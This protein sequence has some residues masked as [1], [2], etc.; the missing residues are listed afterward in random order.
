MI[1]FIKTDNPGLGEIDIAKELSNLLS[2]NKKVLWIFSG[3]SN[4]AIENTILRQLDDNKTNNLRILL[5]DERY[6]QKGHKDSNETQLLAAGFN[7]MKADFVPILNEKSL[8]ETT[9]DF[10][11]NLE[12]SL[13]WADISIG[14]FGIGEDGHTSGILPGSNAINS[15]DVAISYR[16]EEFTRITP[17]IKTL[18][19]INIAYVF[20]F[21]KRKII[22]LNNLKDKKGVIENNP[23][24]VFYQISSVYVYND[25]IGEKI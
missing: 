7:P 5:G 16:T 22:A 4:I 24:L 6:G 1:N 8:E 15:K 25:F 10:I 17:T 13:E 19:R 3:G 12:E 9:A 14:Q 2:E 18:E 21:G 23:C 20:S 11:K